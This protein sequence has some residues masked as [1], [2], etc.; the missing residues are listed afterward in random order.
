MKLAILGTRGIPARH[1]GFETFAERLALYLV[2]H[3][4]EVSVYCPV[5]GAKNVTSSHWNGV[6]LLHLPVTRDDA[7]GTVFFD[8]KSTLHAVREEGTVLNLGYGTALF[9]VIYRWSRNARNI[10]NMDGIEWRREKWSFAERAWL[11]AN[12]RLACWFSHH[13]IADHPE[14]MKHLS[15]RASEQKITMIPYGADVVVDPDVELIKHYN[16]APKSYVVLIARPDP[17]NSILEIVKAFSVRKRGVKLVIL[18]SYNPKAIPYHRQVMAAASDEVFFLGG[19]YDKLVVE[20]LRFFAK[21]YVHGHRV[22]GTNPS[23]VEA[24]AAGSPVLAHNN[25]FNRWV[26]GEGAHYFCDEQQ[27][28]EQFDLLIDDD[29]EL[30]RMSEISLQR[31]HEGFTWES[32]LGAYESLLS[33]WHSVSAAKRSK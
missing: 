14:I 24:L 23:L 25:P 17:D 31:H 18:G 15:T 11:Y 12:E 27:C 6:R 1:G 8:L 29:E 21:L 3:G 9:G 2:S 4:W 5:M 16:L 13:M 20:C 30:G 19:V 22:G 32:V 7:L 33:R 28:A 10:T 26:A